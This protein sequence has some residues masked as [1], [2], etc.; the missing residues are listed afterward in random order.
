MQAPSDNGQICAVPG[1]KGLFWL[2]VPR[3][4]V[5]GGFE[6]VVIE[7]VMAG[8]VA[9][10][11]AHLREAKKQ[12][13]KQEVQYQLPGLALRCLNFFHVANVRHLPAVSQ[14]GNQAFGTRTLIQAAV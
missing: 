7:Y 5:H 1:K 12:R 9:E 11:A 3:V 8:H 6:F 10:E 14:V 2:L 13:E 4:S